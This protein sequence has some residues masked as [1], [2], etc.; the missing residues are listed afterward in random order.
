MGCTPSTPA[1]GTTAATAASN[2][3]PDAASGKVALYAASTKGQHHHQQHRKGSLILTQ[4]ASSPTSA[5]F[6]P[7]FA[8]SSAADDPS[9]EVSA[10]EHN[11][12]NNNSNSSVFCCPRFFGFSCCQQCLYRAST[13]GRGMSYRGHPHHQQHYNQKRISASLTGLHSLD[14]ESTALPPSGTCTPSLSTGAKKR[15]LSGSIRSSCSSLCSVCKQLEE[16]SSTIVQQQQQI[17]TYANVNSSQENCISKTTSGSSSHHQMTPAQQQ[18]WHLSAIGSCQQWVEGAAG[19][20]HSSAVP[21]DS[22]LS[23]K[24]EKGGKKKGAKSAAGAKPEKGNCHQQQTKSSSSKL[25]E[26][27]RLMGSSESSQSQ[28]CPTS[29]A[30]LNS[31]DGGGVQLQMQLS[32][33]TTNTNRCSPVPLPSQQLH[34]H[35]ADDTSRESVI[36]AGSGSGCC[37]KHQHRYYRQQYNCGSHRDHQHHWHCS[38]QPSC[39]PPKCCLTQI[40]D[41]VSSPMAMPDSSLL[42]TTASDS[43]ASNRRQSETRANTNISAVNSNNRG[44]NSGSI[45][46]TRFQQQSVSSVFTLPTTAT[47]TTN[48]A[49]LFDSV[50]LPSR[51]YLSFCQFF[52]CFLFLHCLHLC[53]LHCSHCLSSFVCLV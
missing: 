6:L 30:T 45:F 12:N 13:N 2:R 24:G 25:S 53:P 37:V 9:P 19:G 16:A 42:Q 32:H 27:M 17:T 31:K 18:Q 46:S 47:S 36:L 49:L 10:N 29:N 41:Q 14:P 44:G 38:S 23:N 5:T 1:N 4:D 43:T 22:K 3:A 28:H 34:H 40:L 20:Q 51:L 48:S 52:A 11:N 50:C 7:S 35:S 21:S 15:Q 26:V 8:A 39:P 33:N